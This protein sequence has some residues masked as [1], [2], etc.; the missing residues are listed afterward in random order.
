M[1]WG[2]HRSFCSA[3]DGLSTDKPLIRAYSCQHQNVL[4]RLALELMQFHSKFAHLQGAE[5]SAF[6]ACSQA[7]FLHICL[8]HIN[9]TG[10]GHQPCHNQITLESAQLNSIECLPNSKLISNHLSVRFPTVILGYTVIDP[11][12]PIQRVSTF[13]HSFMWPS[14]SVNQVLQSVAGPQ[15]LTA[16]IQL[17]EWILQMEATELSNQS[18]QRAA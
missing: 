4:L 2:I 15:K 5:H 1:D 18:N 17:S 7:N 9:N 10:G 14:L 6:L 13:T 16:L 11:S 12:L 3:K 8:C